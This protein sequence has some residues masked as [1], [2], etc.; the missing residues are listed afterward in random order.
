MEAEYILSL[1]DLKA[2][3]ERNRNT[4]SQYGG[5]YGGCKKCKRYKECIYKS[6]CSYIDGITH[7][8]LDD[9][10]FP[11]M[12]GF[13]QN[14]VELLHAVPAKAFE[15]AYGLFSSYLPCQFD[16]HAIIENLD[17]ISDVYTLLTDEESKLAFLNVLMY[18]LTL[19]TDYVLRAYS[20]V[21]QYFISEFR[22]LDSD[23]VYV[24]CGAYIGDSL[25]DYCRYNQAP[26]KAYLFEPDPA[27]A[28][29]LHLAVLRYP[30]TE[31][32]ILKK[33]VYKTTGI[34]HLFDGAKECSRLSKEEQSGCIP[35]DVVS[36]DDSIMEHISFLKMDIEGSEKDAILGAANHI[37]EAYPKL[38]ICIYHLIS[39]LWEI[40]LMIKQMFP[41]Y[42]HFE[43]HHHSTGFFDTVLYVYR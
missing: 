33:G 17:R 31:A 12:L 40:P 7:M 15:K 9:T 21:P 41:D 1:D 10:R 28:E 37:R 35:I 16:S 30:N 14:N 8:G 3:C 38:A 11:K 2:F 23:E 19:Q 43:L 13:L 24:D 25:D 20:S 39:D 29:K 18:R 5:V 36:I 4:L 34:L 26:K 27:N 6:K 22:G 42:D 32:V